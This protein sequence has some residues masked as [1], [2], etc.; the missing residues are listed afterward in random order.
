[1]ETTANK[2]KTGDVIQIDNVTTLV[3]GTTKLYK[4]FIKIDLPNKNTRI[5]F[6]TD[7]VVVL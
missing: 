6:K 4:G 2:I 7:L 1:M 5:L 3:S